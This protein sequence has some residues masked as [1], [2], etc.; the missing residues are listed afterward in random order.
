MAGDRSDLVG[1]QL[2]YTPKHNA[3]IALQGQY[4]KTTLLYQ[5]SLTSS[6][7]VDNTN[8]EVLP[9]YH[10]ANL[11]ASQLITYKKTQVTVYVQINN[12][13]GANFQIIANR[14]MPWQQVEIG[15]QVSLK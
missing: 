11:R 12:L 7:F 8:T 6:R 14:P 4:K 13:Y 15:L 5:H 9:W 2:I 10:F 3:N 1:K